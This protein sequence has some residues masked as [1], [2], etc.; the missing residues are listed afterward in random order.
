MRRQRPVLPRLEQFAQALLHSFPALFVQS[1]NLKPGT[2]A[3]RLREILR[4]HF[5]Q[6][7]A[8]MPGWQRAVVIGAWPCLVLL[9]ALIVSIGGSLRTWWRSGRSP[10][11]QFADQLRLAFQDGV[12]P[13]YYYCYELHE[14]ENR[15]CA[16]HY[17]FRGM[18]KRGGLYDRL[19]LCYPERDRC[20]RLLN[21]KIGFQ[22]FLSV[23]GLPRVPLVAV[24]RE[25]RLEWMAPYE[26]RLPPIDLFIKPWKGCGGRGT[27][28]WRFRNGVYYD[29]RGAHLDAEALA[30]RLHRRSKGKALLVQECLANHPALTDLGAGALSTLRIYTMLDEGGEPEHIFSMLRMSRRVGAIVDNV[31]RGGLAAAVDPY[32]G[33]LGPATDFAMLAR[34]GWTDFHPLTGA[35]I[36][37][38]EVPFFRDAVELARAAHKALMAP[39]FVGWDIAITSE[40]PIIIEGNKSPD[41]EVEQR[42]DGPW[43]NTRFGALL[44]FHLENAES[45]GGLSVAT[46][47]PGGAAVPRSV[48]R[49]EQDAWAGTQRGRVDLRKQAR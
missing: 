23:H 15:L 41:I 11:K 45:A 36:T 33:T 42:L 34:T 47:R 14:P 18:T 16:P 21:D 37:G 13:L 29:Q 22:H 25:G 19:Y 35:R 5:R 40:G 10:V 7:V 24:A 46:G 44:A 31:C 17:L 39:F 4:Q 20:A 49:E 2:P 9:A 3:A 27:E 43:G 32:T 30:M 1:R 12:P 8:A 6:R 48:T 26:H 38:R 28:R